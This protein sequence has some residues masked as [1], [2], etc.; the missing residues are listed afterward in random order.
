MTAVKSVAVPLIQI[1]FRG[2]T[3]INAGGRGRGRLLGFVPEKKVSPTKSAQVI[4]L[5]FLSLC[6]SDVYGGIKNEIWRRRVSI[7][8]PLAC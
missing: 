8:V 1:R 5:S 2:K 7:P 3:Q 6:P 4:G